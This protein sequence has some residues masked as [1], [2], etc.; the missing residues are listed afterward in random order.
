MPLYMLTV[1]LT[2]NN[3]KPEDS[4]GIELNT[5]CIV[6][7]VNFYYVSNDEDTR[8]SDLRNQL[9]INLRATELTCSAS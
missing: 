6:G 9:P 5:H 2:K 4:L 1:V 8:P 3:S 7:M